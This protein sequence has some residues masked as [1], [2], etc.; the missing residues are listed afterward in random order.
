[1]LVET[2]PARCHYCRYRC[3]K[4]ELSR[5]ITSKRTIILIMPLLHSASDMCYVYGVTL[6]Q[7]ISNYCPLGINF[8][9]RYATVQRTGEFTDSDA[10]DKERY[11][12]LFLLKISN[13]YY[14]YYYY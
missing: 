9:R 8:L 11:Y 12:L 6:V 13:Y 4:F 7:F 1:M 10:L 5:S 3:Y 2:H 14:Y